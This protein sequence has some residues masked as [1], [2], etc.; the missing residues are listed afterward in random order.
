MKVMRKGILL[1]I[2][3]CVVGVLIVGLVGIERS[4]RAALALA[5][6]VLASQ[7]VREPGQFP[8]VLED[9]GCGEV[10]AA[11][12]ENPVVLT[13]SSPHNFPPTTA[14]GRPWMIHLSGATGSWHGLNGRHEATIVDGLRFSVHVDASGFG[15]FQGQTVNVIRGNHELGALWT[16]NYAGHDRVKGRVLPD[17][18][19]MEIEVPDSYASTANGLQCYGRNIR[20]FIVEQGEAQIMLEQP[21]FNESPSYAVEAGREIHFRNMNEP[22]LNSLRY[23]GRGEDR[24]HTISWVNAAKTEFRVPVQVPDGTYQGLASNQPAQMFICPKLMFTVLFLPRSPGAYPMPSANASEYAKNGPIPQNANRLQLWVRW[25]KRVQRLANNGYIATIGTYAKSPEDPDTRAERFHFYHF[26]NP[27]FYAGRWMQ[28]TINNQ[29]QH[30]RSASGYTVMPLDPMRRGWGYYSAPPWDGRV[31]EYLP[32]LTAFYVD[33][34]HRLADF[35]GQ[36]AIFGPVVFD[37]VEAEPDGYVSSITATYDSDRFGGRK[38]GYE[39]TFFAAKN[40]KDQYEIRYSTEGSLKQRGF[41]AGKDGGRLQGTGQPGNTV[42][43]YSPEMPEVDELW[44]GIRPRMRIAGVSKAGISPIIVSLW[45]EPA[46][47]DGEK[48][49]I[50]DVQGATAANRQ[51]ATVTNREGQ[52]WSLTT[53]LQRIDVAANKGVVSF[54]TPH[55]LVPGQVVEIYNNPNLNLGRVPWQRFYTVHET[56]SPTEFTIRTQGVPDGSYAQDFTANERVS[57]RVLPALVIDGVGSGEY[58]GSGCP[59]QRLCDGGGVVIAA[60]DHK[61][62][63]EVPVYRYDPG[64]PVRDQ[65]LQRKVAAGELGQANRAGAKRTARK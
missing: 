51:G 48:V 65:I 3:T 12:N 47:A 9:W 15:D 61:N 59:A 52:F 13:C 56:P 41:S 37:R 17:G 21:L 32:N 1:M 28:I 22:S 6:T 5:S 31:A 36:T 4:G 26:I 64:R 35:S 50:L 16:P 58:G 46:L 39:V 54:N 44:V 60:D 53:G 42:I 19:G 57:V 20:S 43:W 24:P 7:P 2:G 63:T 40:G 33:T 10:T 8:I 45:Y 49:N 29:P 11:S 34:V 62:F 55:G 38:A 23:T 14:Y 25:G 30:I 18:T 27:N